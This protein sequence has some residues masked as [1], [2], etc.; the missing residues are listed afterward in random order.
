MTCSPRLHGRR[1]AIVGLGLLAL[2]PAPVRAAELAAASSYE[3]PPRKGFY[4]EMSVRPGGVA[5]RDGVVPA[6]R[7]HLTI[8]GG[9]TDR[10]KLGMQLSITSY[11]NGAKKP[12]VG[13]DTIATGYV[14]RGLYVRAGA[15][16][17]SALPVSADGPATRPGF[18]GL[19]G[20][21]YEWTLHKAAALGLGV[22]LDLRA[23]TDR[24]VAR[25]FFVGLHFAFH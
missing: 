13:F 1:A 19:A 23:T 15:G 2:L 4:A 6:L 3:T 14:W 9:L 22:D 12:A 21:G 24:H 10:F 16:V 5:V 8:G 7:T 17:V 25:A 18:G 20:L 11:L